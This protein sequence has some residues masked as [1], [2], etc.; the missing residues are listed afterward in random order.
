[1]LLRVEELQ[2]KFYE[3]SNFKPELIRK[4]FSDA[5]IEIPICQ[6]SDSIGL[7]EPNSN[8]HNGWIVKHKPEIIVIV[9]SRWIANCIE[10]RVLPLD[11]LVKTLGNYVPYDIE[12]D[13]SKTTHRHYYVLE[14][15]RYEK[16]PYPCEPFEKVLLT[17]N[18]ESF[19]IQVQKVEDYYEITKI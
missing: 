12:S 17:N 19:F 13:I 5:T 10:K 3:L 14:N 9:W 8:F 15:D 11:E 18:V 7:H 1:M 6:A 16:K 2:K 4:M